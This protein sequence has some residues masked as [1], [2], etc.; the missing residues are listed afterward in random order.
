MAAGTEA[1]EKI[2]QAII[3]ILKDSYIGEY[4]KKHYFWSEE[5]GTK[6]QVAISLTC[7][8]TPIGTVD[9]SGAFSDGMDFEATPVVAP[10]KF[11]PAEITPEETQNLADLMARLGL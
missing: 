7:P 10:T 2:I 1:K 3:S 11:E 4:D 5:N 9:M 6:K 8:K